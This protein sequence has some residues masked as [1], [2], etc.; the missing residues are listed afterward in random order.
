MIVLNKKI[1]PATW[2]WAIAQQCGMAL[3]CCA[4]RMDE[5]G[6]NPVYRQ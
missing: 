1:K 2:H 3:N 5:S 6:Y 4:C